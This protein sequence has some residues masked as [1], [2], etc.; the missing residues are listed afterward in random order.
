VQHAVYP[1]EVL[2]IDGFTQAVALAH[3]LEL[4]L[5]HILTHIAQIGD[6]GGQKI[7]GRKLDDDETDDRNQPYRHDGDD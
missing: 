6:I 4:F 7:A 5:R 3:G 2:D 1:F